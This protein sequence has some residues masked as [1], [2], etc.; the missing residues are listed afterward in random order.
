MRGDETNRGLPETVLQQPDPMLDEQ[1]PGGFRIGLALLGAAAVVFLVMYGLSQP[2]QEPQTAS[3]PETAQSSGQA[4]TP[5]PSTTGQGQ[6]QNQP[7]DQSPQGQGKSPRSDSAT[8][9]QG[10]ASSDKS[11]P[12]GA[13][14]QP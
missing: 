10:S 2:V 8:I 7:Q 11:A 13:K 1:K 4:A 3:G 12:D 14:K 6:A 5:Q 9:G